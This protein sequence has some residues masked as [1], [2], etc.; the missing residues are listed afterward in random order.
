[1]G[2]ILPLG[3]GCRDRPNHG[4]DTS[5]DWSSAMYYRYPCGGVSRRRFLAASA[6]TAASVPLISGSSPRAAA[7]GV[8][9]IGKTTHHGGDVKTPGKLA[10]PGLYPGPRR[11]G[12][13]PG[14]DPRRHQ[15]RRGHQDDARPRPQGAD[16]RHRRGRGL[17]A[18]LRAGRR[19]GDQGRAQRPALRPLVVRDGARGHREAQVGAVSR[20]SDMFVYDRY[21]GEFMEAGY[22]KILPAGIRWG[23]LDPEG[24]TSSQLDFPVVPPT[25]RSPATTTTRSS[26]W[27]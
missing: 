23:G 21:R 7:Q 2:G 9:P 18:L 13:E 14:D 22:H 12:Q 25:I 3:A 11:R 20:R 16:R 26:G 19:G 1:M 5:W 4:F 17:E 6:I 15:G 27:T 24:A 10:V 8:S